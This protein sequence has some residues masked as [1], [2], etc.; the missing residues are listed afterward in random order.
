MRHSVI[1]TRNA[2]LNHF[3]DEKLPVLPRERIIHFLCSNY[4]EELSSELSTSSEI[5]TLYCM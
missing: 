4:D 3:R 1:E 5:K 2:F